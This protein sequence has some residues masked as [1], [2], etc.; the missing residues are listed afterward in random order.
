[1]SWH[2]KHWI[3][4]FRL[5]CLQFWVIWYR[6]RESFNL[7]KIHKISKSS[8]HLKL[9][10]P[11][12]NHVPKCHIHMYLKYLQ[13]WQLCHFPKNF[14]KRT[15]ERTDKR[16]FKKSSCWIVTSNLYMNFGFEILL[17]L[18]FNGNNQKWNS[19]VIFFKIMVL[20]AQILCY[21]LS[22][23]IVIQITILLTFITFI[24]FIMF[25]I[26]ISF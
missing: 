9:P 10:N 1:M 23:L 17:Q 24:S 15:W 11:S 21:K 18:S 13:G 14:C 22:L 6:I 7:E 20:L 5:Y 4:L 26:Y 12:L 25:I 19:K 2:S 16:I 8:Y 3:I